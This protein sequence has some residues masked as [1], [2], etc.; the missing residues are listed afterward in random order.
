MLNGPAGFVR[1]LPVGISFIGAAW[2]EDT[3]L[4]LAFACEQATKARKEPEFVKTLGY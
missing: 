2:R 3:L 1:G 4:R